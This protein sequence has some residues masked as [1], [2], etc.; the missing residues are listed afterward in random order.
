MIEIRGSKKYTEVVI[1]ECTICET[2]VTIR[3]PQ[4]PESFRKQLMLF[5]MGHEHCKCKEH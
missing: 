1:L 3:K 4:S 5:E 2:W